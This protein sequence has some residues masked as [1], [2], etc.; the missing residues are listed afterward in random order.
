MGHCLPVG[1]GQPIC[2]WLIPADLCYMMHWA[3]VGHLMHIT[4]TSFPACHWHHMLDAIC[5]L[6]LCTYDM[7]T[8]CQ[9]YI[10]AGYSPWPLHICNCIQTG[11][12]ANT[13]TC[14]LPMRHQAPKC[15]PLILQSSTE[16]AL[17]SLL[18][19]CGWLCKVAHLNSSL[20]MHTLL[21][22]HVPVVMLAWQP[23]VQ[24]TSS[25]LRGSLLYQNTKTTWRPSAS[26]PRMG[27]SMTVC[28]RKAM[29]KRNCYTTLHPYAYLGMRRKAMM[30][31]S[32]SQPSLVL[33][34]TFLRRRF[35]YLR[36][37]D[38]NS[39][40]TSN[41]SLTGSQVTHANW[42]TY[43]GSMDPYAILHLCM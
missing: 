39:L 5:M 26:H 1:C 6:M 42:L 27:C 15:A 24:W 8:W 40:A 25:G 31:F 37:R 12:N 14:R 22:L 32:T 3:H 18:T 33:N 23:T 28:T 34:G 30:P 38:K 21:V 4:M 43:N 13:H 20:T 19:N 36:W 35:L 17:Y 2:N 9:C 16:H 10:C 29:T 11:P 41:N 7:L